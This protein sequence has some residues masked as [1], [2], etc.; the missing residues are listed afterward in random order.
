MFLRSAS[1]APPAGSPR[2]AVSV[3]AKHGWRLEYRRCGALGKRDVIEN[4]DSR[5]RPPAGATLDLDSG[6]L[7]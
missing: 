4:V 2:L 6:S 5:L 1:A 7:T 3:E